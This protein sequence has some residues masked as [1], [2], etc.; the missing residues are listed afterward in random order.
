[1]S[2]PAAHPWVITVIVII[3]VISDTAAEVVGAYADAAALIALLL[4]G[5]QTASKCRNGLNGP[6]V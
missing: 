1:M 3:L 4:V 2:N 6:A 5:A